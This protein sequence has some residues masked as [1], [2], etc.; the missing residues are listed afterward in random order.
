MTCAGSANRMRI[1]ARVADII[2]R[3]PVLS[4]LKSSTSTRKMQVSCAEG[5]SK[6]AAYAD[7]VPGLLPQLEFVSFQD[8]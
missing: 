6:R 8:A 1:R 2:Q 4:V 5:D 3:L 7:Y